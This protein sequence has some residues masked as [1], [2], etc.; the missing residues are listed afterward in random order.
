MNQNTLATQ[1]YPLRLFFSEHYGLNTCI[2]ALLS[3]NYTSEQTSKMENKENQEKS[4]PKNK[5][6][7]EVTKAIKD[8][9]EEPMKAK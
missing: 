3:K 8:E 1:L 7:E 2:I 4:K 5:E 6:G 9:E